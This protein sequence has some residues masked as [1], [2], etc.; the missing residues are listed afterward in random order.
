MFSCE[1]YETTKN[2]YFLEYLWTAASVR[3]ITINSRSRLLLLLI[4]MLFYL[5]YLEKI[6]LQ[7]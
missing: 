7:K 4:F 1:V 6:E 2:T 3:E 5:E